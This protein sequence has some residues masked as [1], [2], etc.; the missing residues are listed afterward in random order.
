MK[1]HPINP[2]PQHTAPTIGLPMWRLSAC[3]LAA[4]K[5]VLFAGLGIAIFFGGHLW[6]DRLRAEFWAA[7]A[8]YTGT[9]CG[10]S[11]LWASGTRTVIGWKPIIRAG[12]LTRLAVSLAVSGVVVS[13]VHPEPVFF[14]SVFGM[15]TVGTLWTERLIMKRA[16]GRP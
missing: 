5:L 6:E 4:P 16:L 7:V 13:L 14:W 9:G 11:L 3:L 8:L 10:L 2:H 12:L 1:L 15:A